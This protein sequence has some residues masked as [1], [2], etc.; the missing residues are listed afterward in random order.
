[1]LCETDDATRESI[2]VPESLAA[3]RALADAQD[4]HTELISQQRMQSE[5]ACNAEEAASPLKLVSP[6]I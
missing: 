2:I 3:A 6:E 1:L 4:V 5:V